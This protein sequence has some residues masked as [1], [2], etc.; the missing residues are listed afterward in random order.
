LRSNVRPAGLAPMPSSSAVD[1][2]AAGNATAGDD[3][4]GRVQG[5]GAA[6]CEK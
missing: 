5:A 3:G 4:C 6:G 2:V 1:G